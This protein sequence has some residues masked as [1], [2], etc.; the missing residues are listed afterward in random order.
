MERENELLDKLDIVLE[1]IKENYKEADYMSGGV[2]ALIFKRYSKVKSDI[3]N[4][5][6]YK[7]S[8]QLIKGACRAYLDSYSDYENPLLYKM[9]DVGELADSILE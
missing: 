8:L 7:S 5:I 1:H 2:I 4:D 3:L 6:D 9:S